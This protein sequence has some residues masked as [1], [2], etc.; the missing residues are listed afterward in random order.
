MRIRRK[1]DLDERR[2]HSSNPRSSMPSA[3]ALTLREYRPG[4]EQAILATLER[5][6]AEREP[7]SPPLTLET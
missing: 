4:D 3:D 2:L 6:R 5:A 1:T 7:S